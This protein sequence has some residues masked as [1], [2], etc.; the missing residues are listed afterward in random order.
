MR[1]R[2][3]HRDGASGMI[4]VVV[5]DDHHVERTQTERPQVRHDHA[6]AFVSSLKIG[7]LSKSAMAVF[8]YVEEILILG[9]CFVKV[10]ISSSIAP[11]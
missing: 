11:G 7:F 8:P 2:L 3:Q 1:K 4:A 5:G 6:R 10:I 9:A